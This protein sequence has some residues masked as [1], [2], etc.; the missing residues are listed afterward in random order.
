MKPVVIPTFN[1]SEH[2]IRALQSVL[3]QT[4]RNY[5]VIVV[6]DGSTDDTRHRLQPCME[7]IRY[8]YQEN[9]GA[10]ATRNRGVEATT[11]GDWIYIRLSGFKVW[12]G[13]P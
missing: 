12:Y 10:C 9:Q 6:N 1:R 4:Y 7:W 8:F 11:R 3:G 5:E 13:D 2:L